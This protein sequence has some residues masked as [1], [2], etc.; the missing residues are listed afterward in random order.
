MHILYTST[1]PYVYTRSG[2]KHICAY[3]CRTKKYRVA[4]AVYSIYMSRTEVE[5]RGARDFSDLLYTRQPEPI[6]KAYIFESFESV[7]LIIIRA[8]TR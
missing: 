1:T 7:L 2:Q 6:Y 5:A 3:C 4:Y 8:K